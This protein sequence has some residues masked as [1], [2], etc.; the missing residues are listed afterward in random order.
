MSPKDLVTRL[1][2]AG[3]VALIAVAVSLALWSDGERSYANSFAPTYEVA[4]Q[5]ATPG[6]NSTISFE[7]NIAAPDAIFHSLVTFALWRSSPLARATVPS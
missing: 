1:R 6:A 4:I 5:D 7:F 2:Y 3:L